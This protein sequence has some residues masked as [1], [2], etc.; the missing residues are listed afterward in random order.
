MSRAHSSG[1]HA[2]QGGS[3]AHMMVFCVGAGAGSLELRACSGTHL[4]PALEGGIRKFRTV[5]PTLSL[6]GRQPLA[7]E[8]PRTP[9]FTPVTDTSVP[10]SPSPFSCLFQPLLRR[11]LTPTVLRLT[12]CPSLLRMLTR[13]MMTRSWTLPALRWW[14]TFQQR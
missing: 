8:L 7:L 6:P 12:V 5:L 1:R 13:E 4:R 9:S 14:T 11:S 10:H 3:N 2:L